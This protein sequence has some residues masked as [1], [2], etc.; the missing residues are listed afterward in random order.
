MVKEHIKVHPHATFRG[1]QPV[2]SRDIQ[3]QRFQRL[4]FQAPA[5]CAGCV[6]AP[7]ASCACRPHRYLEAHKVWRRSVH[8]RVRYSSKFYPSPK[9]GVFFRSCAPSRPEPHRTRSSS[10]NRGC[11]WWIHPQPKFG[12]D[13]PVV[14][15]GDV[16]IKSVTRQME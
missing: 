4:K 9:I 7:P 2:N 11:Q 15:T 13:Q 16:S 3:D 1:D 10:W 12:E 5:V 14:N 6:S 8:K